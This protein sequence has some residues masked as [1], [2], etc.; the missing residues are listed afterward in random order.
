MNNEK[1]CTR[2]DLTQGDVPLFLLIMKHIAHGQGVWVIKD[3]CSSVKI[4]SVFDKILL[5]F[6]IVVAHLHLVNSPHDNTLSIHMSI[7]V[8]LRKLAPAATES[9]P[10]APEVVPTSWWQ[11]LHV[12]RQSGQGTGLTLE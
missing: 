6:R 8:S 5:V 4:N 10:L 12:P 9:S 1:N 11:G 2:A 7:L 3:K